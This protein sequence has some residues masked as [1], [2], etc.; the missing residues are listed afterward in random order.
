[1]LPKAI[2]KFPKINTNPLETFENLLKSFMFL[3][4]ALQKFRTFSKSFE[5]L[6]L[7]VWTN[8]AGGS[9]TWFKL[10]PKLSKLILKRPVVNL[11]GCVLK[12]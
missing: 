9:K 12:F 8:L 1:M 6:L 2:P 7:F 3:A 11:E 5:I 4:E 10:R